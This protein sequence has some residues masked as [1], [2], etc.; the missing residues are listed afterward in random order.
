MA[1]QAGTQIRPELAN[2]DMSGFYRAAEISAQALANLGQ[3]IG[4]GIKARQAK[5]EERDTKKRRSEYIYGL[6]QSE[7]GLGSALRELGVTDADSANVVVET[8][9]NNFMPVLSQVQEHIAMAEDQ[10]ILNQA[11]AV[12]TDAKGNVDYGNVLSSYIELG[13]RDTQGVAQLV[14]GMTGGG[15]SEAEQEIRR[16][17]SANPDLSYTDVVNIKEGVSKIVTDPVTGKTTIVNIA[18]GEQKPLRQSEVT[19]VATSAALDPGPDADPSSLNLYQIAET[20]TGFFP[21]LAATAQR[22]TGQV[23]VDVADPEL[24][25]NLQT[26]Q[27]AQSDIRR[28]MRSAPKFMASEMAML[29]KELDISPSALKDPT[30][31]L[32]QLRS[33]DKSIRNRLEMIADAVNDPNL[34]TDEVANALRLQKDL[35]NFLRNLNVPQDEGGAGIEERNL[36][37]ENQQRVSDVANKY[38]NNQ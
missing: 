10:N 34:P 25:E 28:S 8:L 4:A 19:D 35:I 3:E 21:A 6:S 37:P 17:M 27:T 36:P 26:F 30:T 14:G 15:L 29:D 7:T 11:M 22:F 12:N 33:V 5:K 32:A 1:F 31:L 9:G 13:G 18:T 16:V 24:L 20:T 23:G 2:A 38:L